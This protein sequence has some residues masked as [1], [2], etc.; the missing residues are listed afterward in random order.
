MFLLK[1]F[2]TF[3]LMPTSVVLVLALASAL[4][5]LKKRHRLAAVAA[6]LCALVFGLLS[7]RTVSN[8]LARPLEEP[9]RSDRQAQA[10]EE[11]YPFLSSCRF[12]VV[13]GGGN[14]E[15]PGISA[16]GR[17]ST[18]SLG[19]LSEAVR[20]SRM[21][22]EATLV[23]SGPGAPGHPTHASVMREAAI[24]LGVLPA[25]IRLIESARD[26][27][28]EAQA[29]AAVV[30]NARVALVTS[31]WHLKRASLLFRKAGVSFEP[32][33]ADFCTFEAQGWDYSSL[34]WD[35]ESFERSTRA[36]HEDLGI[37]WL[38]LKGY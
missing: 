10:S 26:T 30:G 13:L 2:V 27:E 24:S 12:I 33:P 16:L 15:T 1:K 32:C 11:P 35:S 25:R 3:W 9:F 38:R 22:P 4:W 37:L 29:V 34:S 31:A 18:S 36:I 28:E 23:L 6:C 20:L 5:I 19:R 14:T 8:A 7:N 17:L 21:N